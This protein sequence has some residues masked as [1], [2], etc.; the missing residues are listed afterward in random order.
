[1]A[2]L[3]CVIIILMALTLVYNIQLGQGC[4][5]KGD[6]Q[7]LHH[8]QHRKQRSLGRTQGQ[9]QGCWKFPGLS[10]CYKLPTLLSMLNALGNLQT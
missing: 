9:D 5:G 4:P 7:R 8:Y 10:G 6:F 2:R 1:M 3:A